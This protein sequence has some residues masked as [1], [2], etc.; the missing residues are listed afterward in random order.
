MNITAGIVT[1]N[2]QIEQ[3]TKN[4]NAILPQVAYLII[5]DNGSHNHHD[6][7]TLIES[8]EN[9]ILLSSRTNQGIAF[10]LNQIMLKAQSLQIDWV[11]L[12]DQD[13]IVSPNLIQAYQ[14]VIDMDDVALITPQ[15]IDINKHHHFEVNTQV[16]PHY[17]IVNFAITSGSCVNVP[18]WEKIGQF[19]TDFFIDKVDTDFSI[20]LVLYGYVQIQCLNT[21]ILHEVGKAEQTVLNFIYKLFPNG[22]T[23]AWGF[24][25]NHS[26][27]RVYYRT[28]NA[29]WLVRKYKYYHSSLKGYL[30]V[31]YELIRTLLIEKHKRRLLHSIIN[32]I[33]DGFNHKVKTFTK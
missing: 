20:R 16:E 8:K 17:R 31:G 28:R 7:I 22:H 21:Y 1:Y 3:L 24:R 9:V 14:E 5:F 12:L 25:T 15:I 30:K 32:G 23:Q 33:K 27:L 18:I 29:I 11:C 6:I 19:D 2:P 10:A 13:S 4:I 26:P